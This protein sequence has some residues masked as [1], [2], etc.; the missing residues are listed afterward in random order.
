MNASTQL[1]RRGSSV[2]LAA[3]SSVAILA[4]CIAVAPSWSK[5][6]SSSAPQ[7]T[8][9]RVEVDLVT[10]PVSVVDRNNRPVSDLTK[11]DFQIY[12]ED[13]LQ[14]ITLFEAETHQPLDLALMM[15]SSMSTELDFPEERDAVDRF[16]KDVVRPGDGLAFFT[17]ADDVTER[18]DFTDDVPKLQQS[19]QKVRE[20]AGTALYDAVVL[21]SQELKQRKSDRRR[22]IIMITDAGETTSK[23]SFETARND[24]IAS[25]AL[26]YTI[27]LNPV[28]NESG[29][30]TAGEHALQTITETT[31]GAIFKPE[32]VS[33]L[34]TI[35]SRINRELRTQYRLGF[36][37]DPKPPAGELRHLKLVVKGDYI[38]RYRQAYIAP[39]PKTKAN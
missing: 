31:G 34:D 39:G 10:V 18:C 28:H 13:K 35:F 16:I 12:D 32:N 4:C 9:M 11:D 17:F 29:R 37:P 20:G 5:P 26:L 1:A 7:Q 21:G 36:Y 15:D 24:A 23:S 27:V 19:V 3:I 38:P 6:T 2:Y 14:A 8:P 25:D 30:N 33:E 22:V